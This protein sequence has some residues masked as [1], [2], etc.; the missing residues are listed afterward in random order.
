[1]K[2]YMSLTA[3]ALVVPAA[4]MGQTVTTNCTS[5]Y[6]GSVNCT[7]RQNGGVV[8]YQPL[9]VQGAIDYA[10]SVMPDYAQQRAQEQQLQLQRQQF[11]LQRQQVQQQQRLSE[12]QQQRLAEQQ[13]QA[14]QAEDA[15]KT[16]L[17]ND[18]QAEPPPSDEQPVM[19]V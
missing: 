16:A 5:Y 12:Q 6:A 15:I 3:L 2:L 9:D 17:A 11:Q 18:T 19:L 13:F 7:S 1:M 14:R 10:R 8:G 4:A